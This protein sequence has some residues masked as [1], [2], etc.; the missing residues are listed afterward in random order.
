MPALLIINYN[1]TDPD[2]LVGYRDAATPILVGP[3][4]GALRVVSDQTVDLDEGAG[5]GSTTVILEF[6]T[7][8]VAREIYNSAEYQSIIGDRLAA[9][10]PVHAMIVPTLET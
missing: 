8:E 6:P 10:E 3:D 4:K 2:S 1:V 9:T 7:V 5:V